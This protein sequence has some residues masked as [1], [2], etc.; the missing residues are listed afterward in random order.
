MQRL[1]AFAVSAA[2][3]FGAAWAGPTLA[4]ESDIV[5]VWKIS[6][7]KLSNSCRIEGEMTVTRIATNKYACRLDT[8]ETCPGFEGGAKQSC[9][10]ERKGDALSIKSKVISFSWDGGSY[11]PDDFE[12]KIVSPSYM[13]GQFSSTHANGGTDRA[14][15]EFFRGPAPTS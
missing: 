11:A 5:G 7:P 2:A 13:R 1:L 6:V 15:A 12:M 3:I 8:R 9:S 4:N 14:E 10:A